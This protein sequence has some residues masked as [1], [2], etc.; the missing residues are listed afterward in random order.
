MKKIRKKSAKGS[1]TI[2]AA[3]VM[4]LILFVLIGTLYLC[5]F[6]HNRAWLTAAAYEAA[7]AGSMEGIREDGKMADTA[8][9]RSKELGNIGFFGAENL[10][11]RVTAEKS[12]KVFY[13][14]DTIADFGAF[15]WKLKAEGESKVIHPVRWIRKVKAVADIAQID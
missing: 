4:F 15:S 2:E 11:V 1:F 13:S 8:E 7:L 12:V 6:V 9:M 14:A 5:F 3:C 10:N